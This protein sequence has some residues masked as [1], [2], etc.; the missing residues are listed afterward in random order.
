VGGVEH[1]S[2]YGTDSKQCFMAISEVAI[3]GG[4]APRI[5]KIRGT[6]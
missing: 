6:I 4:E 3:S 2:S 1:N 5:L